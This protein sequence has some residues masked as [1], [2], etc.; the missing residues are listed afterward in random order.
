M[1]T[2]WN[3]DIPTIFFCITRDKSAFVLPYG[4]RSNSSGVGSSVASAKD[5]NESMI[6]FTHSICTAFNGLDDVTHAP[7]KATTTATTFTVN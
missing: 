4:L 1:T 3:I 2:N 7:M 6:R 5:A